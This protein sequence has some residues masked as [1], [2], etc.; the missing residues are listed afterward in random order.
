[1]SIIKETKIALQIAQENLSQDPA[2]VAE[3]GHRTKR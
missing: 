1:M 3:N 2:L